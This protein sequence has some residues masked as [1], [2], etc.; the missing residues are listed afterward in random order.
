NNYVGCSSYRPTEDGS[1]KARKEQIAACH[2]LMIDDIGT[3]VPLER[4]AGLELSWL[5]ETS[6][7]NYQGGILLDEPIGDGAEVTQLLKA[8]I[9]AGLC[10]A[11]ASQPMSR[12]ARLPVAI[13]GKP[14]Y[15][16]VGK[17]FRC[18]LVEWHPERRY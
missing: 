6:P 11:G 7:D 17:P 18:R 13:N 2:F 4:L 12:W 3:K 9:E 1:L 8:I 16:Q 15:A 5:I 14:K 10:D